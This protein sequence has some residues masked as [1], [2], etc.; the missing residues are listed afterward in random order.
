MIPMP[1]RNATYH[2]APAIKLL[3]E[4]LGYNTSTIL[5]ISQLEN[6]FVGKDNQVFVYELNKEVVGFIAVH[7]LPQLGFGGGLV[8]ITYLAVYETIKDQRIG[9]ALEQYVTGQAKLRKCDRIQ[10][11]CQSQWAES[12]QFYERQGYGKYPEFLQRGWC[13]ANKRNIT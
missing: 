11:H 2:D 13:M 7:F 10:V 6:L 3:L 4:T 5:L 9:A 1:I 8:W 12:H